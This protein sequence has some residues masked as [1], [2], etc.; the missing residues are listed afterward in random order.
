M[1]V[2]PPASA[3]VRRSQCT[4][5]DTT[6]N[7]VTYLNKRMKEISDTTCDVK[8][9]FSDFFQESQKDKEFFRKRFKED[10]EY[11]KANKSSFKTLM[12]NIKSL[13]GFVR[14]ISQNM[15]CRDRSYKA[16]TKTM[17][18]KYTADNVK[19]EGYSPAFY[20]DQRART[21]AL[22]ESIKT[23]ELSRINPDIIA[24]QE[25]Q[26]YEEDNKITGHI[27]HSRAIFESAFQGDSKWG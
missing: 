5:V 21:Q 15:H 26:E 1:S 16:T 11:N 3:S 18:L 17:G 2:R 20:D 7:V 9:I 19:C 10:F 13:P 23:G 27:K 25:M 12:T 14:I 6:G 24:I 4:P 8:P 22:V